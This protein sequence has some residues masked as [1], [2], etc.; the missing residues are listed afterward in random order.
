RLQSREERK[1]FY[2][3]F[4]WIFSLVLFLGILTRLKSL[5][6]LLFKLQIAEISPRQILNDN[7]PSFVTFRLEQSGQRVLCP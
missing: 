1:K 7:I 5:L 6:L 4:S 3:A 2:Y